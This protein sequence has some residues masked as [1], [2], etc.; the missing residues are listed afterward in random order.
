VYTGKYR[1]YLEEWDKLGLVADLSGLAHGCCEHDILV[2]AKSEKVLEQL[3][4]CRFLS[5]PLRL[6]ATLRAIQ[7]KKLGCVVISDGICL[8]YQQHN[9][10]FQIQC[11]TIYTTIFDLVYLH[12]QAVKH[13]KYQF[14]N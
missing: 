14:L 5:T 2:S 6:I 9:Y 10:A 12:L 11:A 1:D 13:L 4:D 8:L 7:I 3:R